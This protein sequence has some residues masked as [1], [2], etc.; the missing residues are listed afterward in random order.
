MDPIVGHIYIFGHSL[1]TSDKDILKEIIL[2]P[3][4]D[5]TIF[6]KDKVQQ[7]QQIANLCKV[8]GQNSLLEG[9]NAVIPTII[10]KKQADMVP[11]DP[12]T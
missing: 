8:I 7:S 12:K 11:I 3:G 6:Y 9:V 5:T 2:A 4:F 1:D 10:F